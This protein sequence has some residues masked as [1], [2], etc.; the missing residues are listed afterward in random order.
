MSLT[1]YM[2]RRLIAIIPIVFGVMTLTFFLSR[3]MPGDPVIALLQARGV[4]HIDPATI[5]AKRRELGLDLPLI[6]QY[7]RY[8]ADLFTGNWGESISVATGTEVIELI[9]R[10]LLE[11]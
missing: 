2:V 8:L 9:G 4:P 3:M 7:F 5:A 1:K 11:L 6:L 10:R